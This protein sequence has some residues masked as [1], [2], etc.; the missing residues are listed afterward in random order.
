MNEI[1][2]KHA[3]QDYEVTKM[4]HMPYTGGT[5]STRKPTPM[6][7]IGYKVHRSA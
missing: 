6:L 2:K 5:N 4:F 7:T 1:V 3:G